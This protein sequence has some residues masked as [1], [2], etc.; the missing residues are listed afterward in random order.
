M[1]IMWDDVGILRTGERLHQGLEKLASL[2]SELL[3]TGLANDNRV[4]NLSWHD[5][6]NLQSL[7]DVSEVVASAALS[8]ENS[9]GAH[10]RED[11]TSIGSLDNSYFTVAT[12]MRDEIEINKSP[13]V[14]SIVKPGESLIDD[15]SF[16]DS[17]RER[18]Q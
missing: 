6:L 18:S 2:K 13:V 5:W 16:V 14:F 3:D 15:D 12:R 9:L 8:R 4:F 11:Y 7:I 10:F 17:N 1:D